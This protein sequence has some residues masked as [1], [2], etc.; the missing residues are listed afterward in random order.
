MTSRKISA[1]SVESMETSPSMLPRKGVDNGATCVICGAFMKRNTDLPRHMLIHSKDKESLMFTCPIDG[2]T[3]QTL[4]RSNLATHIR[5][6]TRAKP[7]KCPDTY[8]DGIKCD[9]STADPSSLHR[10]RKRKHGYKSRARPEPQ[11]VGHYRVR[12]GGN[13]VRA[14]S[15]ESAASSCESEESFGLH[16]EASGSK[17]PQQTEPSHSPGPFPVSDERH[18]PPIPEEREP[19]SDPPTTLDNVSDER[20]DRNVST[21]EPAPVNPTSG[22]HTETSP[23]MPDPMAADKPQDAMHVDEPLNPPTSEVPRD[24]PASNDS[25][26]DERCPSAALGKP[27]DMTAVD[28]PHDPPS[29]LAVDRPQEP[30]TI[31]KPEEPMILDKPH[32]LPPPDKPHDV[33]A[34]DKLHDPPALELPRQPSTSE[35]PDSHNK[36]TDDEPHDPPVSEQPAPANSVALHDRNEAMLVDVSAYPDPAIPD[37]RAASVL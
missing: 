5:T 17:R 13:L 37:K 18:E 8:P 26:S 32:E 9:F 21:I 15:V 6:H 22:T 2:C 31:E 33:P 34:L 25:V 23:E 10:H 20:S 3:H 30:T 11:V 12:V 36:P 29:P 24:E 27:R 1:T 16:P 35:N 19:N 28:K 14:E 7:H 4:Q